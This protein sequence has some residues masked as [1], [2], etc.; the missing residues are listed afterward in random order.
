MGDIVIETGVK[1]EGWKRDDPVSKKADNLK[2]QLEILQKQINT[3]TPLLQDED[4]T[5]LKK[6]LRMYKKDIKRL[7]N[8][9]YKRYLNEGLI[10]VVKTY[11][12]I[13]KDFVSTLT[14][15]IKVKKERKNV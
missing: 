3:T 1:T 10:P 15:K 8:N 9:P 11:I 6:S 5:L 7:E 13:L 2:E 4:T 12:D 14:E